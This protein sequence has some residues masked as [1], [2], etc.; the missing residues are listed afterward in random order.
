M[1][2]VFLV[3][4]TFLQFEKDIL[5]LLYTQQKLLNHIMITVCIQPQLTGFLKVRCTKD[6]SECRSILSFSKFYPPRLHDINEFDCRLP[7]FTWLSNVFRSSNQTE[8]PRI[9][10]QKYWQMQKTKSF[11]L[12]IWYI[13]SRNVFAQTWNYNVSKLCGV[14]L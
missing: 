11:Y 3:Q 10:R 12:D 6:F 1:Y 7:F 9:V 2:I 8:L 14:L 13:F 5:V 4:I